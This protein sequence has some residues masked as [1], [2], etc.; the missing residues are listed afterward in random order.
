MPCPAAEPVDP[1]GR[2]LI[3]HF[4]IHSSIASTNTWL[5]WQPS[6]VPDE[7]S[8][9]RD[10]LPQGCV[11]RDYTVQEALGHGG[12]GIVYKARHNEFDP[13]LAIKE[14][15]PSELAVREGSTI[16]ARTAE[17]ETHFADGLRLFRE[18]AK[19]RIEFQQHP[20]IVDCHALFRASVPAH[21][22]MECVERWPLS[23]LHRQREAV[24][25]PIGFS[26]CC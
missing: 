17:C 19:G 18:E 13:V 12:F 11:L 16:H 26:T 8:D 3:T 15:L 7:W 24:G 14:Y 21:L 2:Y 20:S 1:N 9:R 4:S 25:Q 6:L 5:L 23:K 10:A 22:V